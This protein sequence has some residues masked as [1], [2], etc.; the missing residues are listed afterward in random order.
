MADKRD[1]RRDDNKSSLNAV[2][3]SESIL[4]CPEQDVET[5]YP[6][7]NHFIRKITEDNQLLRHIQKFPD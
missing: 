5:K 1:K 4:F 2:S 3:L 6:N 7:S